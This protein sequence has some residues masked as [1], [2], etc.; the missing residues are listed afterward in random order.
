MAK[1][2]IVYESKYG[3]TKQVAETIAEGMRQVAGVEVL[4][5]ELKQVDSKQLAGFDA[6]L[7]GS[8]NHIGNA[9]GGIRKFISNLEKLQSESKSGAV[10]DTYM[11][12]GFEIAVKK[13]EK[14]IG[15]RH[16]G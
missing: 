10:F 12:T 14:Q 16:P 9:T 5:N 1:A 6:I 7:I 13:M 8:P 3:N 2:I 15:K 11:G 4:V